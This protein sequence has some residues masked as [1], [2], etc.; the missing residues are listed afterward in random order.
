MA[1]TVLICDDE[2]LERQVLTLIVKNS[3]LPLEIV[4]GAK[5]GFEAV[6][7]S[8]KLKPD[9]LFMDI[10]MPGKDGITAATEIKK[11]HPEGQTI[12][13]TAYDEFE[14]AKK[15][16]KIGATEFLL[17]PVRPDEIMALLK[18]TV[19]LLNR[20]KEKK[21]KE[22][23]LLGSIKKA[24]NILKSGIIA[25]MLMGN[26][27]DE[28]VLKS[29]AK[30]LGIKEL[31]S[32]IVVILPDVKPHSV[33]AELNRY[34]VYKYIEKMFSENENI[35]LFLMSEEIILG[36]PSS[37]GSALAVAENI[38]KK[39]KEDLDID[40]TV[41][42]GEG[43]KDVSGLFQEA[44]LA[45]RLG[46]FFIG[47][48]EV[49]T[50]EILSEFLGDISEYRIDKENTLIKYVK[51]GDYERSS[52][53]MKE[54]LEEIFNLGKGSLL[55]CQVRIAELM[56]MVCRAARQ[57]G[58]IEPENAY[59]HTAHLKKLGHC[60]TYVS[61]KLCCECFLEDVFSKR[62]KLSNEKLIRQTIQYIEDNY[63]KDLKLWKLAKRVFISPDYFS[64][65]F[66]KVAGCTYAEYITKVRID[67]AKILLSNPVISIAEVAKKTGY[68][69]PNYFSRVFK[70]NV[71]MP[72]S[73]YKKIQNLQ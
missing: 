2:L 62:N 29:Q 51:T 69:D 44:L 73:E 9:I 14:Y 7:L 10:K 31:P 59:F 50:N 60:K 61:L 23:K 12:F 15:A 63:N 65:L 70:K 25:S 24:K 64:R 36:I 16:L 13:I 1:Y 67:N 40:V 46:K 22:K 47:T 18:K 32:S 21:R 34:E 55:F 43:N 54:I 35:F 26:I 5:D 8:R 38:R 33:N 28:R 52:K 4:G 48:N 17:K 58:L 3:N 66:K 27:D 19:D 39:I 20:E 30:L 68:S 56:V 57:A 71:G 11:F 49:V 45:A 42:I 6:N 37:R 72:P 53:L 41:G